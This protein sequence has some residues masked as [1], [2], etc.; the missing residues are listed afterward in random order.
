MHFTPLGN[1]LTPYP[2]CAFTAG[3]HIIENSETLMRL[4]I[5]NR[6]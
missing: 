3:W 6:R 2:I 4:K 1:R 5:P